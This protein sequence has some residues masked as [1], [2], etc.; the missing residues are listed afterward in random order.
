MKGKLPLKPLDIPVI[1]LSLALCIGT[2]IMVYTVPRGEAR[3][4]IRGPDRAWV[5]PLNVEEVVSVPG[6]LGDTLIEIHGGNA[7]IT[8][9]P[10]NNQTC[11]AQ[12]RLSRQ[13]QWTACL[14]N[15][16]FLLIEG[17]VDNAPDASAW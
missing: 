2:G 7:A 16:V 8:A 13:G 4:I 14:P 1:L 5:F 9:S 15:T 10:C 12:G 3:V 17:K 6:P 11:V